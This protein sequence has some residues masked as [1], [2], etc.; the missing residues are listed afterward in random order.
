MKNQLKI[1]LHCYFN[2][3]FNGEFILNLPEFTVILFEGW[4]FLPENLKISYSAPYSE[5]KKAINLFNFLTLNIDRFEVEN[6]T[7]KIL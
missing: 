4:A 1:F 5:L 3:G 6:K 7:I 2:V